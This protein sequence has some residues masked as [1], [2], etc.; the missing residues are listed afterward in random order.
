MQKWKDLLDAKDRELIQK[1]EEIAS[2]QGMLS[3]QQEEQQDIHDLLKKRSHSQHSDL[4]SLDGLRGALKERDLTIARLK[5][6]LKTLQGGIFL[7]FQDC[8]I[9]RLKVTRYGNT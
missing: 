9:L 2:L 4:A 8:I 5:E 3:M 6:Q 1:N 7:L